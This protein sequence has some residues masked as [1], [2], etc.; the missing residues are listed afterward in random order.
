MRPKSRGRWSL[1]TVFMVVVQIFWI[2][3]RFEVTAQTKYLG[4]IAKHGLS[5]PAS[6]DTY[7]D[8]ITPE[9]S[10]KW[11]LVESTPD[12][13]DWSSLDTIYHYAKARGY[14]FKQHTFVWGNQQP[15]WMTGLSNAEQ[16]LQV[17]EW[18]SAFAARYP[19]TDYA[20]VVNEP[21]H[22]PPSYKDALGGDGETGWDWVI[23]SFEKARTYLPNTQL[24]IN[25]YGVLAGDVS[26]REYADLINLLYAR[27]LVDGVGVQAHL[28]ARGVDPVIVK[29]RLDELASLIAVPIHISEVS[30]DSSNDATQ[31]TIFEAIIPVMWEHPRVAGITFWG[32]IQGQTW[33]KNAWVLYGDQVRRRPALDWLIAYMNGETGTGLA[34]PTDLAIAG[35]SG[36][37]IDLRWV[38][39]AST[40][41]V[42]EVERSS[43]SG[44]FARIAVLDAN[45]TNYSDTGLQR[46]TIYS[47]RV[48][49]C[50]AVDC[51]AYSNAVT[52]KTR[53]R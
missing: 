11:G 52:A 50:E 41:S 28:N 5:L 38:D 20:D 31:K 8:Q 32:Y 51:S 27:G 45:S 15:T 16:A 43:G 46:S 9:N 18:I 53:P 48:R 13:M 3:S 30:V 24:L 37:E 14:P 36:S 19:D 49:A 12:M 47:Y 1:I 40:E 39:R 26:P 34:A 29:V 35:V 25:E 7:W 33:K 2:G 6:F 22:N 21:F 10:G 42:Y 23:W 4:N 44:A 17:E